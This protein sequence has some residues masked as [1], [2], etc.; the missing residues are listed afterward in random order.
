MSAHPPHRLRRVVLWSCGLV[1]LLS[2]IYYLRS[3]VLAGLA[4][5]WMVNDPPAK[6]DAIVALPAL[7]TLSTRIAALEEGLEPFA[8]AANLD[9]EIVGTERLR[10]LR[11]CISLEDFARARTI[12]AGKDKP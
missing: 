8:K 7:S 5:T 12:F 2:T 11:G 10:L 9:W 3:P 4:N 6:A 1:V